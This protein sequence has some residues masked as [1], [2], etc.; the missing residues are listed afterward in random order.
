MKPNAKPQWPVKPKYTFED[1][2]D[3]PCKM[4]SSP[5]KSP[6]HTTR[7]CYFVKRIAKGKTLPP[8]PPP[9]PQNRGP[10]QAQNQYPRQ[11][12]AYMIFTSES[13][14]KGSRKARA[15]EFNATMPAIPQFM[16]WSDCRITWGREDHPSIMPNPGTYPLVVDAL[17]AAPKFSC[18]FSRVLIDGGSTINIL[19]RDTLVK[20]GLTERDL[21]RNLT[22]FHGIVPGL[23]CT[24]MGRIRLD[25]IF[26]IEENFRREPIWFEVADLSSPY[27]APLGLPTFAKFMSNAQ[28]TYLKMKIPGPNGV[29]TVTGDFRKSL[30]CTSAGSSLADSLVVET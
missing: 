7:Q 20:L 6:A 5:G 9:P 25:V 2:L 1:M 19:Y 18:L 26:G 17:F 16:Q 13:S 30:E 22:T 4:H 11:D 29:I 23:S 21:E 12:D 10:P 24:P 28:Q 3:Q 15:Q 14:D 8:P 27:H